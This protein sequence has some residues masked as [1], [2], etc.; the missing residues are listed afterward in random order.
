MNFGR[1]RSLGWV[2]VGAA[3]CVAAFFAYSFLPLSAPLMFNSPDENAN[4]VFAVGFAETGRMHRLEPLNVRLDGAVHPR[5][6]KVVDDLQVP[7]GF[8]GLPFIYGAIGK[9]VGTVNIPLLTPLFALLGVIAWGLLL[10]RLYGNT[11]GLAAALLLAANP[12]WWY[13]SARTM[14]PN[15]PFMS[16]LL[17]TLYFFVC[18]PFASLLERHGAEGLHLLR[19]SDYAIAGIFFGLALAVRPV[20][21][22]WLVLAAVTV[23]L[24]VRR[25]PWRGVAVAFAFAVMTLAPFIVLNDSL[26][27][28]LFSTGY[29][30]VAATVTDDAHQGMGAN[31]LGPL[32]PV[33]F[34][35]G[36]APRTASAN[37][38]SF[39]LRLFWGWTVLVGIAALMLLRERRHRGI[40]P[41]SAASRAFLASGAVVTVW[42]I[43]FYGSYV[44]QDN[45]VAGAVTIGV[46]YTRYWLPMFV[47]STVPIALALAR[48]LERQAG[49]RWSRPAAAVFFALLVIMS[50]RTVFSAEQEGLSAVHAT[51]TDNYVKHEVVIGMTEP[52]AI[53][54][55]DRSDKNIFPDRAVIYPLRDERTYGLLP[56]AIAARPTYYFGITFPERDMDYLRRVKLPP[57]GVTIEPVVTV[58][59][60]T[61]YRFGRVSQE[62]TQDENFEVD[63]TM[64]H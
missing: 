25:I 55:A 42:L 37:F 28:G 12:A 4:H 62:E 59:D 33:L 54:I 44:L 13:W 53:V 11:V 22:Y 50:G 47:L 15:V 52:D 3:L 18:R 41:F 35:L 34:P 43:L 1:T 10:R 60:E 21:L 5:S 64:G 46:S 9:A 6:V 49:K 32:R 45:S 7:G 38:W 31:L 20:E 14:M 40:A 61:L 17:L 8:L 2:A 29:G 26:Y 27:G 24:V 30:D 19:S 48:F 39:G 51:L 58:G 23:A 56:E 63:D 16:L 36:F 57:L